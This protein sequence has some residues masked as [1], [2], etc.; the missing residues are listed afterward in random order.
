MLPTYFMTCSTR[1]AWITRN[2]KGSSDLEVD[3]HGGTG[4][5]L[6]TFVVVVGRSSSSSRS[7]SSSSVN[8]PG[9]GRVDID[10]FPYKDRIPNI[11]MEYL[12]GWNDV[13]PDGNCGF[14]VVADVFQMGEDNYALVRQMYNEIASNR[15]D[16]RHVYGQ[17]LDSSLWRI[18]WGGGPCGQ[19]HWFDVPLDLFAVANIYKCAVMHFGLGLYSQ[20]YIPC[21]TVLP[22]CSHA[23]VT[24]LVRESAIAFLGSSH[25]HFIQ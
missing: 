20:A 14:R 6:S 2:L 25:R 23:T 5:H 11:I 7:Q 8:M 4:V 3:N 22:W 1:H 12:D 21:T 18:R 9:T 15:D 10:Q 24:R 13:V 17:D 19:N 16:Y